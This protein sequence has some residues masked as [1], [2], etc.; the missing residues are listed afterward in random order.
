MNQ[1][2]WEEEP[3]SVKPVSGETAGL[4]K[5]ASLGLASHERNV[6]AGDAKIVQLTGRELAEFIDGVAITAPVVVRA[7]EVHLAIPSSL[8]NWS[9]VQFI[10][11]V[12]HDISYCFRR[13]QTRVCIAA[14]RVLHDTLNRLDWRG[15]KL[16]QS[17]L[18]PLFAVGIVSYMFSNA[19]GCDTDN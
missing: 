18:I 5:L 6:R 16:P 2:W 11:F 13:L 19:Y 10:S 15:T 17:D 3:D 9:S 14:V 4:V 7:E 1:A 12:V 8:R